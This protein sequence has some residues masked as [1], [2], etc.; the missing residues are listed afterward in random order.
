MTISDSLSDVYLVPYSVE[1]WP[2][3]QGSI[4]DRIASA[5]YRA[6]SYLTDPVCKVHELFRRLSLVGSLNETSSRVANLARKFILTV[7]IIANASVGAFTTLPGIAL[8]HFASQIQTKTYDS[9]ID[10]QQ[11]EKSLSPDRSFSLLS[12]NVCFSHAG[13]SITD[14][15]VMPGSFRIDRVV[16]QIIKKG[17]DVNCL[18]EVF[19]VNTGWYIVEKLKNHGYSH[20][21]FNF[22][23]R[24]VGVTAGIFVA[25][26]YSIENPEFTPFSQD[27][28]VGRTKHCAKGVFGFD[29]VSEGKPFAKIFATHLQH[30]EEPAFPT[31]EEV[32]ARKKQMLIITTKANAIRDRGVLVTGDLNLDDR[33]YKHSFWKSRFEKKDDFSAFTWGGDG[34]CATLVG[35][36]ISSPLN[37]DHTMALKGSVQDLHTTIVETGFDGA[38]FKEE[39]L[40]DHSGLYSQV[41]VW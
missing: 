40:S 18:Y 37:L 33:E 12:W 2:E 29:L 3:P 13:Y 27:L 32:E 6:A 14:G 25:S 38:V 35:K 8:R 23:A 34:F 10:P 15:G 20:F 31:S 39:A 7:G 16:D 28:L 26:K 24:G 1:V 30:S 11:R 41:T 17:A 19:D 21:Y 9:F 4:R 22:G 36:R 5:S